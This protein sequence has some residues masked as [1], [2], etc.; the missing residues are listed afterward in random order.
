VSSRP[1]IQIVADH[2]VQAD[3]ALGER[4]I[5]LGTNDAHEMLQLTEIAKPGPFGPQTHVLGTYVGYRDR[6]KL[7]A[8]GGRR[9]HLPGFVE[10]SAICVHPDARGRGLGTGI[11]S[12]LT[13]MAWAHGETPFLHV[14]PDNPA[15]ALYR[16]LGFRER[17]Q[18]W[19][20]WRRVRSA[21]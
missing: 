13:R 5:E 15:V 8:M 11:T 17:A 20:I 6:G 3:A 10:L 18:L 21:K 1:I 4:L 12:H 9:F 16:R 19:V 7:S 14:F 2:S